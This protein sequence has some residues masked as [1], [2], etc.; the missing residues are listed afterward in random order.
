MTLTAAVE[1][2]RLNQCRTPGC[3]FTREQHGEWMERCARGAEHGHRHD[4][5]THAHHP[6]K[7]M[8]GK[9]PKSRIVAV[10]C[11]PLHNATDNGLNGMGVARG[12]VRI[13]DVHNNTILRGPAPSDTGEDAAGA[14]GTASFA[15][16]VSPGA[17]P[18]GRASDGDEPQGTKAITPSAIPP[19]GGESAESLSPPTL[20]SPFTF[21]DNGI[22]WEPEYT[23]D[24]WREAAQRITKESV[25]RQW[26]VGDLV[27]AERWAECSQDYGDIA[28]PPET[29]ANYGRVAAAYK[30]AE[31][32]SISFAH[33]QA[34][35]K[36]DDRLSL[37]DAAMENG[38]TR[39]ELKGVA[40][41]DTPKPAKRYSAGE[42]RE[43]LAAWPG[44][45]AVRNNGR[46]FCQAFIGSLEA[47]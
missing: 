26:R 44:A 38:W 39:A 7:G 35:Y 1:R 31:R 8:G 17:G 18:G 20:P 2:T 34:I 9:N 19:R 4:Q 14:G 22:E 36:H 40:Y 3:P 27:N 32:R 42:L 47:G 37:L 15:L 16:P 13:W 43:R 25:G 23:L 30:L 12:E 28:Y 6:R 29:Q 11:W 41:P 45:P 24:H 10:I 46:K 5:P 21:H 33:H